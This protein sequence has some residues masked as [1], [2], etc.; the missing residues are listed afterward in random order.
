M[1]KKLGTSLMDVPLVD[2]KLRASDK[3]LPVNRKLESKSNMGLN[4]AWILKKVVQL[5][6]LL[7]DFHLDMVIAVGVFTFCLFQLIKVISA[8]LD[9]VRESLRHTM[10]E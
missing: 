6:R 3:D 10:D 7:D 2:A 5:L 8:H 1:T 9:R 4:L